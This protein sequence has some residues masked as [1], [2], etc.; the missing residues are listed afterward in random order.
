M[1]ASHASGS[2]NLV[3]PE[4]LVVKTSLDRLSVWERSVKSGV[5]VW[6]GRFVCLCLK[7]CVSMSFCGCVPSITSAPLP[8]FLM[9]SWSLWHSYNLVPI[10][11]LSLFTRQRLLFGLPLLHCRSAT[12]PRRRF[13]PWSSSPSLRWSSGQTPPSSGRRGTSWPFPTVLGSSR[14]AQLLF[15][16]KHIM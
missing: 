9:W 13:T 3:S 11:Q 2:L 8:R 12:G 5:G 1:F 7:S 6:R 10:V 4:R 15:D 16:W 14:C